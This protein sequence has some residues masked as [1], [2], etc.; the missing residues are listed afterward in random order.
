MSASCEQG[1]AHDNGACDGAQ[2]PSQA[3]TA[4]VLTAPAWPQYTMSTARPVLS[5]VHSGRSK[6][7]LMSFWG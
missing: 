1:D 4:P 6:I 7:L 5:A 3:S 2:P